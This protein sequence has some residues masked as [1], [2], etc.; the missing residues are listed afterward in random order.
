L[1]PDNSDN[2]KIN[3][4]LNRR[5]IEIL[6]D[7][8]ESTYSVDVYN[9]A[10]KPSKSKQKIDID[11]ELP[12]KT[13]T[14]QPKVEKSGF[15]MCSVNEIFEVYDEISEINGSNLLSKCVNT[16]IQVNDAISDKSLE[17][18]SKAFDVS[19]V[20]NL[21]VKATK[22]FI[23]V[24]RHF[25]FNNEIVSLVENHQKSSEISSFKRTNERNS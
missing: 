3:A 5:M 13:K 12:A 8:F 22:V 23:E 20:S 18:I 15:S 4:M 7:Y 17:E 6:V 9:I 19:L 16:I 14:E 21:L 24:D 10:K 25:K 2:K 1:N 11:N